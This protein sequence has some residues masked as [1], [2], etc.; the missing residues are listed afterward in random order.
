MFT[1]CLIT[2][3]RNKCFYMYVFRSAFLSRFFPDGQFVY[4]TSPD[5]VRNAAKSL[6]LSPGKGKADSQVE[7]GIW[8]LNV[9]TSSCKHLRHHLS[10]LNAKQWSLCEAFDKH[11]IVLRQAVQPLFIVS[12]RKGFAAYSCWSAPVSLYSLHPLSL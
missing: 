10:M 2:G 8:R 4:R 1:T 11:C 12:Q 3:H 9:S 6:Q 7:R 5:V